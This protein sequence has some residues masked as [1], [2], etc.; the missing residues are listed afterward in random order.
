MG[1]SAGG[2]GGSRRR[3]LP[4]GCW[5]ACAGRSRISISRAVFRRCADGVIEVP[6]VHD[7]AEHG[8]V[9]AIDARVT[10]CC[11]T[12][13]GLAERHVLWCRRCEY[14]GTILDDVTFTLQVPAQARDRLTFSFETDTSGSTAP[15]RLRLRVGSTGSD[16]RDFPHPYPLPAARERAN[17]R[18]DSGSR[19]GCMEGEQ[20]TKRVVRP[21]PGRGERVGVR[22]VARGCV[23][24]GTGLDIHCSSCTADTKR[25]SGL[26]RA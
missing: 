12:C 25:T 23:Q 17:S 21:L 6:L 5:N 14:A 15:L 11:P 1:G 26:V 16:A 4:A 22:E 20:L 8:G 13:S 24:N 2:A 10:V 9:A 7:E 19:D 18:G 3:W